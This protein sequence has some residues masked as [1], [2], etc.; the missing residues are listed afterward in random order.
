MEFKQFG[1]LDPFNILKL[2]GG[3]IATNLKENVF[4][5]ASL[6]QFMA[7]YEHT[8]KQ[9][10]GI[11]SEIPNAF[12]QEFSGTMNLSGVK[13]EINSFFDH[14]SRRDVFTKVWD[15]DKQRGSNRFFR[16]ISKE[17]A[18]KIFPIFVRCF[19]AF[20]TDHN[21]ARNLFNGLVGCK[22]KHEVIHKLI[23][24]EEISGEEY[25]KLKFLYKLK[26]HGIKYL[27]I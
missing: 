16:D 23:K 22:N 2:G 11:I 25:R 8:Y 18:Y 5:S 12:P 21:K 6:P 7:V 9:L 1:N 3:R 14:I 27:S 4:K 10:N 13:Y 15:L 26:L 24:R 20:S 17:D 19:D